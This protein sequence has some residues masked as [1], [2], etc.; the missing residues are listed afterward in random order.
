MTNPSC[1]CWRFTP[2]QKAEAVALRLGI[3]VSS[4]AKWVRQ[5][6]IDRGELA[7]PGQGPS[8]SKEHAELVQLRREN[9]ELRRESIFSG[10]RQ[11]T[12]RKSSCRREVS[13]N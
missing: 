9:Q 4:L 12:L 11:R 8:I 1:A 3:P 10:C 13:S 6:C 5:A 7:S 2:Q